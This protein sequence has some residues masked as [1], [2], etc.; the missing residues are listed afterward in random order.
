MA[1]AKILSV[2]LLSLAKSMHL[3]LK[4]RHLTAERLLQSPLFRTVVEAY[5]LGKY[6]NFQ[7]RKHSIIVFKL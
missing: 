4:K 1:F 3:G 5:R 6:D 2:R 7:L